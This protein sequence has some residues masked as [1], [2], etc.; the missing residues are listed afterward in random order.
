VVGPVIEAKILLIALIIILTPVQSLA[1]IAVIPKNDTGIL[2]VYATAP[3]KVALDGSGR[4]GVFTTYL[5]ELLSEPNLEVQ[6][7]IAQLR[8]RVSNETDRKQIPWAELSLNRPFYF[9]KPG[10]E[11]RRALVIGNSDYAAFP[12]C[13]LI[14]DTQDIRKILEKQGFS[15]GIIRKSPCI[16]T[17]ITIRKS[18][19]N[20]ISVYS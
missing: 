11:V 6:D 5:L 8:Q 18:Q 12:L 9:S 13:N 15:R 2:V 19:L 10:T 17:E 7:L 3:G 1:G 4:N 14:N 20:L 16:L